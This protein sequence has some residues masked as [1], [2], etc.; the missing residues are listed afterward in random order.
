MVTSE[1]LGYFGSLGN[2]VLQPYLYLGLGRRPSG[3]DS[4]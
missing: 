1:F 4:G 3:P 2:S